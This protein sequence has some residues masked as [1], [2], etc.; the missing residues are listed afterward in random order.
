MMRQV[1]VASLVLLAGACQQ[2]REPQSAAVGCFAAISVVH[3][4]EPGR[5]LAPLSYEIGRLEGAGVEWRAEAAQTIRSVLLLDAQAEARG[6]QSP[7]RIQ[8]VA[9]AREWGAKQ[10]EV[11]EDLA[12]KVE[13]P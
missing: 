3:L 12:S 10:G 1:V 13:Q 9:C 4:R 5:W 11:L 6:E 8:A 2:Q 7:S